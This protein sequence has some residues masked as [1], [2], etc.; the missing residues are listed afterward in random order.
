MDQCHK[1]NFW[2][3]WVLPTES[4]LSKL[5][6]KTIQLKS[7]Y[8][9]AT[10]DFAVQMKWGQNAGGTP[11]TLFLSPAVCDSSG[12]AGAPAP[13]PGDARNSLQRKTTNAHFSNELFAS[14]FCPSLADDRASWQ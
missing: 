1:D 3:V 9:I 13:P 4:K 8:T 5:R 7:L 11:A 12:T 2:N 14:R 6:P 10:R